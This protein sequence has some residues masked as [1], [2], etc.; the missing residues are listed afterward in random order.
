MCARSTADRL[1]GAC[2]DGVLVEL[3]LVDGGAH[4]WPGSSGRGH[5]EALVASGVLA[6]RRLPEGQPGAQ[7]S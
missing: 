6:R 5:D 4:T 1:R 3:H 2:E 7:R